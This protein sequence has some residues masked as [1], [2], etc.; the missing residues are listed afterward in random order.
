MGVMNDFDCDPDALTTLCGQLIEHAGQAEALTTTLGGITADTG[1]ADSDEMGRIGPGA[2][3]ELLGRVRAELDGDGVR[4]TTTA[5]DY[6]LTDEG[7]RNAFS[8]ILGWQ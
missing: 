5:A 1:R 8:R 4:I 6:V 2:V 3:A 7:R